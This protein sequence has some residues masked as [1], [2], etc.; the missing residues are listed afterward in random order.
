MTRSAEFSLLAKHEG[1]SGSS[2]HAHTV[3]TAGGES[4]IRSH[5]S[6]TLV[7][8][9]DSF[10]ASDTNVDASNGLGAEFGRAQGARF[11]R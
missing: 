7:V 6:F 1:K 5:L 4:A 3:V 2:V 10:T 9:A 11:S 8:A